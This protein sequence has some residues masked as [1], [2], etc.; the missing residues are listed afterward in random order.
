[1]SMAKPLGAGLAAFGRF[2]TARTGS[3]AALF[4]TMADFAQGIDLLD[5]DRT[6]FTV[7]ARP[8]VA[9]VDCLPRVLRLN[10]L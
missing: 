8:Y 7:G 2:A 6:V 9:S 3:P 5:A 1:M 4:E 10:G